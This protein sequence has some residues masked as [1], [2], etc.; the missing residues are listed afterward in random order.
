MI[1]FS[2]LTAVAVLLLSS[3][4]LASSCLPEATLDSGIIIGTTTSLTSAT[5]TEQISRH[6]LC[7]VASRK[8]LSPDPTKSVDNTNKCFCV[9]AGMC[10]TVQL[11]V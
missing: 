6:T 1:K 4:V 5:A 9:E 10:S 8:V 2:D 11:W 7:F 3:A